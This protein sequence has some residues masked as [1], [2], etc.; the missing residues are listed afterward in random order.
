MEEQ[1]PALPSLSLF[2]S[3]HSSSQQDGAPPGP[4]APVPHSGISEL[5]QSH[6]ASHRHPSKY[7]ILEPR[8][9]EQFGVYFALSLSGRP[10]L[11]NVCA[12]KDKNPHAG[13]RRL[14]A[15]CLSHLPLSIAT[16]KKS[17]HTHSLR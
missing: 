11:G 16:D 12:H 1:R 2:P 13:S 10:D 8:L 3:Q 9:R 6:T 5:C 4:P 17:P 14:T 7:D 15:L